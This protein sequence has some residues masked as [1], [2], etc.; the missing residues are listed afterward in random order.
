MDIH[1]GPASSFSGRA[2]EVGG[3]FLFDADDG[4]HGRELWGTDGTEAGTHLVMDIWPGDSGSAPGRLQQFNGS[5]FFSADDGN[6]GTELWKTDGTEAGTLLV[7][8]IW[9]GEV[10]SSVDALTPA[11]GTLFF[12]ADDGMA[13]EELWKS[14]GTEEGTVVALDIAPG[15]FSSNPSNL[16][17]AGSRLFFAANELLTGRELWAGRA[18]ILALRPDR[19]IR[20][21]G[22]E[23]KALGLDRGIERSLTAKLDAAATTLDQGESPA[24]IYLLEVF[25][26]EV[27]RR[28]PEMISEP[29]A[30]NLL[31]F[32]LEVI[33]VLEVE[34]QR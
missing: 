1:P 15:G 13:G 33:G 17:V 34:G 9:P 26:R 14:D 18:A 27:E 25:V 11:A 20:D 10:G 8:D 22:D 3:T 28:S 7:K 19:A 29:A 4:I 30:A 21:L 16:V 23:V 6:A 32:A 31:E 5:L 24:A 2:F 12:T